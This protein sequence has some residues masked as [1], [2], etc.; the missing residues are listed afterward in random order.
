MLVAAGVD[1]GLA[2]WAK[3][4]HFS[5]DLA[6]IHVS[7]KAPDFVLPSLDESRSIRLSDFR[8]QKPV[9]LVF[10]NFY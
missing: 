4:H 8:G 1:A 7:M 2:K 6:E 10:G 5:D 9:V 3:P